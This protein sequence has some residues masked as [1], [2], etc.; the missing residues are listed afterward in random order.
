MD[1]EPA[2]WSALPSKSTWAVCPRAP[3]NKT[4]T[5]SMKRKRY[6]REIITDPFLWFD[7]NVPLVK[8]YK[9]A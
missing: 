7:I 9:K 2:G 3:I 8:L 5:V 6:F 4:P 1:D